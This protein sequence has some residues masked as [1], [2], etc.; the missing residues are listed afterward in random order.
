MLKLLIFDG[1]ETLWS[2]MPLYSEAKAKFARLMRRHVGTPCSTAIE[3]LEVLDRENV[4]RFGFS[5]RRFP[6]SMAEGY[7]CLAESTGQRPDPDLRIR[8]QA[9]GASVFQLPARR[10][11]GTNRVLSLLRAHG[12]AMVLC[13]K[14]DDDV[15]R[16]RICASGVSRFFDKVYVVPQKSEREF[17]EILKEQHVDPTEACSIG[18]SARSDINPALGLGMSA[19]WI[20]KDTWSFEAECVLSTPRLN[21][22][23]DLRDLP[24]TIDA[25]R[26]A[27]AGGHAYECSQAGV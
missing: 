24:D 9:V 20:Q 5:A 26:I 11:K 19:V 13:T 6:T 7:V 18:D 2:T 12:F 14:G 21:V 3:T 16:S 25:V 4:K 8:V 15:Q 22:I 23:A 27:L 10:I 1:D 17:I